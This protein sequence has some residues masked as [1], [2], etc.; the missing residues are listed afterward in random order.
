MNINDDVIREWFYRLPK[1]YAEAPYSESELFVLADVI[2]EHDTTVGKPIPEAVELVTEEDDTAEYMSNEKSFE[3]YIMRNYAVAG[4]KIIG[5]KSLYTF[6]LSKNNTDLIDLI[7]IDAKN[8]MPITTGA[9]KIDGIYELLYDSIDQSIKIPNGESSELWFAIVYNGQVKGA[10]AGE[11][12]IEADVIIGNDGVS[13]KNYTR[14]TF[15]FGSLP[16]QATKILNTFLEI[17]K[18]ITNKDL[19]KSKGRQPINDLLDLLDNESVES[20]IRQLLKMSTDTDI[21][22]IQKLGDKIRK[23]YSLNDDLDKLISV[24]C[25][26]IDNMVIEKL[27]TFEYWALILKSTKTIYIENSDDLINI[28]KCKNDRLSPAIANFHQNKLFVLGSQLSTP[29]SKRG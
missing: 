15:D 13:V 10:V 24:F 2:A 28:L 25:N 11:E 14:T 1:G 20:D 18:L 22:L 7:S 29:I 26:E 5:L 6:I 16:V 3:D 8:K 27:S 21:K 23:L 4:Q 9:T 12:G 19:P 17:F